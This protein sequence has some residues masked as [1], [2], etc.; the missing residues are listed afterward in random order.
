MRTPS[1]TLLLSI[2]VILAGACSYGAQDSSRVIGRDLQSDMNESSSSDSS[3]SGIGRIYLQRSDNESTQRLVVVQ[4]DVLN[5]PPQIINALFDGPTNSE[6]DQSL[7]SAIPQGT[8]L[9]S[10]R[11]VATDIV[12]VDI[13]ENIFQATGDDLISAV[14]QIVLTLSEIQGVERIL[15]AVQGKTQEWPRGDGSLTSEPLTSFDY[16]GRAASSQPAFPAIVDP[17]L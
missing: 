7:R 14:A 11:Y 10:A 2:I 4:R 12:K 6:Q 3:E 13:S 16:P 15:I 17:L 1:R 9:I 8:K 5:E